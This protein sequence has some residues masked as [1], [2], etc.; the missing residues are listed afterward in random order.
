M[1]PT[2]GRRPLA[3]AIQLLAKSISCLGLALPKCV[4]EGA[5]EFEGARTEQDMAALIPSYPG[6]ILHPKDSI[7]RA[8]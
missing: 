3:P 2:Y 4:P 7:K 6:E 8:A 1:A 5:E